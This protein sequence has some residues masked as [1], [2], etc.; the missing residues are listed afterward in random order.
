MKSGFMCHLPSGITLDGQ[1]FLEGF[2]E[3][4]N[5]LKLKAVSSI[6]PKNLSIFLHSILLAAFVLLLA[7]NAD[8]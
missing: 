2:T 3:R 7:S 1:F 5:V 4:M 8:S 6:F